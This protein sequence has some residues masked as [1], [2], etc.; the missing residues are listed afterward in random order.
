MRDHEAGIIQMNK[1]FI[2]NS[3]I[4]IIAILALT[5]CFYKFG[6]EKVIFVYPKDVETN[7]KIID[8]LKKEEALGFVF[9]LPENFMLAEKLTKKKEN[10]VVYRTE[11]NSIVFI[12]KKDRPDLF[13]MKTFS[14]K[15][16]P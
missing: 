7:H 8:G 1:K 2:K 9:L 12:L 6:L 3:I 16:F 10:M 11:D 14:R 4:L 13:S 5:F 15:H